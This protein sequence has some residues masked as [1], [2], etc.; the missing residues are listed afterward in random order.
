MHDPELII[1]PYFY[2]TRDD[3]VHTGLQGGDSATF[4]VMEYKKFSFLD[5]P[6][7][8]ALE[9][10]FT[11]A[12]FV[13]NEAH[14]HLIDYYG[15]TYMHAD[16]VQEL[17]THSF[18][19]ENQKALGFVLFDFDYRD[20]ELAQQL[21]ASFAMNG[22]LGFTVPYLNNS[23]EYLMNKQLGNGF[24]GCAVFAGMISLMGL[25]VVQY[26]TV[27][28]RGR[29]IAMMRCIGVS[30]RQ[31]FWMFMLE[32]IAISSLGLLTGWGIGASGAKLFAESAKQDMPEYHTF[33]TGYPYEI[34][35]PVMLGLLVLSVLVN[36]APARAAL[37]QKPAEGLR[38]SEE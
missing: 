36:I 28:E 1:L 17:K 37:K 8:Q 12:G 35:V 2:K 16:V 34:I 11:V 24:V 19:W 21:E 23:A 32:G 7:V 3:V 18:K 22:V 14:E 13:Q 20:A 33:V 38:A 31:I 29:Q 25:A 26:R 27:R 9:K 6:K 5:E 15:A 10:R 30:G 4:P